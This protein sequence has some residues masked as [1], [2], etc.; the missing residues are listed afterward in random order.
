MTP[1][2]YNFST[3]EG[4]GYREFAAILDNTMRSYLKTN[5]YMRKGGCGSINSPRVEAG[6]SGVQSHLN[7]MSLKPAW[8]M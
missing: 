2:A 4:E 3:W 8:A 1:C 6:E 7:Y 5:K